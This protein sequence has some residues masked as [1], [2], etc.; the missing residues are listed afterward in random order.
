VQQWSNKLLTVVAG[1]AQRYLSTYIV[2]RLSNTTLDLQQNQQ[3]ELLHICNLS[4]VQW[5]HGKGADVYTSQLCLQSSETA[6]ATQSPA[7][8]LIGSQAQKTR[9]AKATKTLTPT[10]PQKTLTKSNIKM[11]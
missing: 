7:L 2:C 6:A 3:N 11:F 8:H 9:I 1:A 5:L 10:I 4:A